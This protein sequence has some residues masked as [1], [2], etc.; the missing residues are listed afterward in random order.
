MKACVSTEQP[1]GNKNAKHAKSKNNLQKPKKLWKQFY[2]LAY[3]KLNW[4]C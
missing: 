1:E 2:I 3:G 4:N